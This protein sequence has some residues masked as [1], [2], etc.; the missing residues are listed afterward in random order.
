MSASGLLFAANHSSLRVQVPTPAFHPLIIRG[1]SYEHGVRSYEHL[2]TPPC[3]HVLTYH[4]QPPYRHADAIQYPYAACCIP[5]QRTV[6][7]HKPGQTALNG[8]YQDTMAD[9]CTHMDGSAYIITHQP[10]VGQSGH[11]QTTTNHHDHHRWDRSD[12]EGHSMTRP[13]MSDPGVL[14]GARHW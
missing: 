13:D 3:Q 14:T 8:A 1:C 10:R 2:S 11:P 5:M 9:C 6:P 12:I 4:S 7:L